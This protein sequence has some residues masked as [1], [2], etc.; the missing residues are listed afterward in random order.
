MNR[1][2][3]LH[4]NNHN[5]IRLDK[6]REGQI[7]KYFCCVSLAS[8]HMCPASTRHW[9]NAGLLLPHRLRRWPALNQHWFNALCLLEYI[10]G[11]C[12]LKTVTA[13]FSSNQLLHLAFQCK[14]AADQDLSHCP[15]SSFKIIKK[16]TLIFLNVRPEDCICAVKCNIQMHVEYKINII[17]N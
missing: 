9:T 17:I 14:I 11:I 3:G 2:L 10:H 16:Q 7:T 12:S 4:D 13:L 5:K 1:A 15:T 6:T 8:D